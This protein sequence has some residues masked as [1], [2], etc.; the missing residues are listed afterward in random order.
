[1]KVTIS[2]RGVLKKKFPEIKDKIVEIPEGSTC[3]D[4]L[5]SVGIFYKEIDNFGFVSVNSKRV[6]IYD[7]LSDGDLLK[8]YSRVSGG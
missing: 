5:E 2:L 8:A 3:E 6:M 7:E 4:A 1:M